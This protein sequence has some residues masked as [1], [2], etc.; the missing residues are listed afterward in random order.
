MINFINYSENGFNC[1]TIFIE[2]QLLQ[3]QLSS[4][5]ALTTFTEI[6][7]MFYSISSLLVISF[8]L[9][10]TSKYSNK[11]IFSSFIQSKL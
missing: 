11:L 7:K 6:S 8:K 9:F 1:S 2:I 10:S 3:Y 4:L 5:L